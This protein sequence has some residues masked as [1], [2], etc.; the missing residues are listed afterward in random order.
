MSQSTPKLYLVH[1]C[2]LVP[3]L[4]PPPPILLLDETLVIIDTGQNFAHES[5]GVKGKIFLQTKISGCIYI[6]SSYYKYHRTIYWSDVSSNPPKIKRASMDGSGVETVIS[7]WNVNTF[8]F[9]LDFSQQMLYW[10]ND[11]DICNHTNFIG[12]SSVN[13]Y[14]GIRVDY[15]TSNSCYYRR[16]QAIDFFGGAIYTYSVQ[17]RKIFKSVVQHVLNITSFAY[18]DKYMSYSS[19]YMY[20]GMKIISS[21]RQLQG[22]RFF[23]LILL[24][25]DTMALAVIII[26]HNNDYN[27]YCIGTNPCAINNGGCAHLCLLSYT[28][29]RNY[30]CACHSGTQLHLNG[31]DCIGKSVLHIPIQCMIVLHACINNNNNIL[32]ALHDI[33]QVE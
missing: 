18:V 5:K 14:S 19:Y 30:T 28:D 15:D 7:L 2:P 21:K 22:I 17:H 20:S 29:Q 25:L 32:H 9:T 11:S 6:Y 3:P 26:M 23:F 1:V 16:T 27:I 31:H 13:G 4:P 8:L 33:I 24:I 10:V 12:R